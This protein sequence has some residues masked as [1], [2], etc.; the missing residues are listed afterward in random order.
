MVL[1]IDKIR[2]GAMKAIS[3]YES[4]HDKKKIIMLKMLFY[5]MMKYTNRLEKILPHKRVVLKEEMEKQKWINGTRASSVTND[6]TG[7]PPK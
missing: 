5:T 6:T 7:R 4:A 1:D 2:T 3:H